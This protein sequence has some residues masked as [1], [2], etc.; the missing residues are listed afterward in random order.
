M[1]IAEQRFRRSPSAVSSEVLDEMVIYCPA[2]SQA[3]SLNES[4]RAIWELCDGTR[5][6]DQICAE[7]AQAVG[8]EPADLR[9]DVDA[10]II[11]LRDLGVLLPA[12]A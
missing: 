12:S 11:R 9:S 7:L 5:S 8:G 10:A 1:C 2:T 4:A 3:L 6:V